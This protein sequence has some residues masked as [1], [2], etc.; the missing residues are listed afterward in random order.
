[1]SPVPKGYKRPV[2]ILRFYVDQQITADDLKA[3]EFAS[4]L[5]QTVVA[6]VVDGGIVLAARPS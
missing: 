6:R 3:L 2:E 1:M 4:K 5:N